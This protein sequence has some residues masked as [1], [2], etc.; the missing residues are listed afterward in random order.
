MSQ[1]IDTISN[2]HSFEFFNTVKKYFERRKAYKSTLHE[3]NRLSDAELRD[4]GINR[5]MI[6]SIAM[7]VYYDA[8]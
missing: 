2:V 7:E 8:R 1:L 4:I 5:G 6:Q 3:L